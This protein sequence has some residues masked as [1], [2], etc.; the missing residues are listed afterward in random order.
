MSR[1]G[2]GRSASPRSYT[3]ACH[4]R[5]RVEP[6]VMH[7]PQ[8]ITRSVRPRQQDLNT[9][10]RRFVRP[11]SKAMRAWQVRASPP[12]K[13]RA[14]DALSWRLAQNVTLLTEHRRGGGREVQSI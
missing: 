14:P 11:R 10:R 3:E 9:A 2:A 4:Q 5:L 1:G 13:T 8:A 6:L 7:T 12:E